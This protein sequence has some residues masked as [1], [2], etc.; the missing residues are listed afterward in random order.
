MYL[1]FGPDVL[2]TARHMIPDPK[3]TGASLGYLVYAAP[4]LLAPHLLHL[5]VLGLVTSSVFCGKEAGRWR[6][7]A[8]VVGLVLAAADFGAL[9]S[10]DH[11]GNARVARAADIDAFFWKRR[12]V[13]RLGLCVVDGLLGWVVWL[14]A[15]KRAFVELPGS[16]ERVEAQTRVLEATVGKLRGLGA[17][18]NVVFRDTLLRSKLERYWVQEQEVMRAVFEDREV[19]GALNETLGG[20]DIGRIEGDAQSYVESILGNVRVVQEGG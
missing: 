16:A 18:R 12:L 17:V 11:A 19:V 6:T 3:A 8:L 1:K 5:A 2:G 15:T 9:A 13:S 4:A 7:L 14:T 10:Y 20:M